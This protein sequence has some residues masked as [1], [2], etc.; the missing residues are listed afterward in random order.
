MLQFKQDV[1]EG[2][3]SI[4]DEAPK[5]RNYTVFGKDQGKLMDRDFA[6]S[7][8]RKVHS[9]SLDYMKNIKKLAPAEQQHE[10]QFIMQGFADTLYW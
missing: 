8:H 4:T 10:S 9:L 2:N 3:Y 1:S 7:I 6:I 5:T